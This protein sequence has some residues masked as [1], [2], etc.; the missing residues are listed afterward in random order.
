MQIALLRGRDF[1]SRD[2]ATNTPSAIVNAAF[3]QRFFGTTDV[4]GRQVA[5]TPF[6]SGQKPIAQTIVGVVDNTRTSFSRPAEPQLYVPFDQIPLALFYVVRT[7]NARVPVGTIAAD[8]VSRI[9]PSV[10]A[11]AVQSYD[12][13]LARDAVRSQAAM[14]LFGILALLALILSLAG[15]YAVTAYSVERRTQEFGIR[16]AV[17]AAPTNVLRDVLRSAL[18]QSAVGIAVGIAFAGVFTRFL[19]GL[20]FDVSPLDPPTFAGV[21]ALTLAAVI[22]AA[23]IP[24]VRAARVQPAAAIRYE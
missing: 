15:I 10:A 23:A 5:L 9:D 4:V 11:P 24:A 3:A 6:V 1:S 17:G 21:I 16:Q 2:T 7:E 12:A 20:L 18:L 19:A 8:D 22:A 14:L 13:L